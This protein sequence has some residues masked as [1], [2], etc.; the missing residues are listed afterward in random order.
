MVEKRI[1]I[2][3]IYKSWEKE[4]FCKNCN[5]KFVTTK[6]KISNNKNGV[7]CSRK[8]YGEYQ[9]KKISGKN[10]PKYK[11]KVNV[12]CN[13]CGKHFEK[14]PSVANICNK[15]GKTHNFCSY[16]CYWDFRKKYYKGD[17][18]YNTGKKMN[19]EFCNKIRNAILKQYNNKTI[20]RMTKPQSIVNEILSK[21]NIKYINE[22]TFKYYSVDNFLEEY[23]LIIEV[24]GDYY[25]ANPIT[26][27]S[28][29]SLNSMQKSDVFRDRRKHTFIKKY[30]GIEIL[31]LWENDIINNQSLCEKL[32]LYY[33]N[34]NGYLSNYNSFNYSLYENQIFLSQNIINPYFL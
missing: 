21:N 8:C 23:N 11:P 15:E 28:F 16:Q 29:S 14:R 12:I 25:H 31:Y 10:N 3:K 5:K 6:Y 7:F 4:T 27:Y 2:Q 26:Y 19:D 18:L 17:K 13:N 20:N 32:I 1:I 34:Q 24:M 22:E 33:I 30:Y 9:R